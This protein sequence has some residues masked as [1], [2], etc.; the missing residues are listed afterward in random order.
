MALAGR[1][2]CFGGPA[3][4]SPATHPPARLA[5][6]SLL[7]HECYFSDANAD[8]ARRTGHSWTTSVAQVARAAGVGRLVLTHVDPLSPDHDPIGLE[9]ARAIFP[10]TEIGEDLM[11]LEF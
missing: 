10:Q 6:P 4:R 3:H 2:R 8:W 9:V 7:V 1:D 11:E 5:D